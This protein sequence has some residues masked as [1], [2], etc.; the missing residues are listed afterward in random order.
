MKTRALLLVALLLMF[1][2]AAALAKTIIFVTSQTAKTESCPDLS[3]D[4][5]LYCDEIK[6]LGHTLIVKNELAVSTNTWNSDASSAD[7]IFLGNVSRQMINLTESARDF[8]NYVYYSVSGGLSARNIPVISTSINNYKN[9][10]AGILGCGASRIISTSPQGSNPVPDI[11]ACDDGS[12]SKET[13]GYLTRGY[14]GV[15]PVYTKSSSALIADTAIS[16]APASTIWLSEECVPRGRPSSSYASYPSVFSLGGTMFFGPSSPQTFTQDMWK[17]FRRSVLLMLNDYSMNFTHFTIPNYPT[18]DGK[19]LV[20]AATQP[21]TKNA[22][23]IISAGDFSSN[24]TYSNRTGFFESGEFSLGES[25]SFFISAETKDGLRIAN[26]TATVGLGKI[27][28]SQISAI[29]KDSETISVRT[30]VENPS[31]ITEAKYKIWAQNLTQLASGGL[32]FSGGVFQSEANVSEG[33]ITIEVDFSNR[34]GDVGGAYKFLAVQGKPVAGKDYLISPNEWLLSYADPKTVSQNFTISALGQNITGIR[35]SKSGNASDALAIDSS[36]ALS[37]VRKGN[38]TA[39]SAS[40]DLSKIS[41]RAYA[42]ILVYSNEFNAEIPI[43]AFV[44]KATLEGS[45]W[46][47]VNPKTWTAIIP[48]G[49]LQ[50]KNFTLTS[51]GPYHASEITFSATDSFEGL[52][53][54]EAASFL[55]AGQDS[56]ALLTLNTKSLAPGKYSGKINLRSSIGS[57]S[58]DVSIEIVKDFSS[59]ISEL[60][61][62]ITSEEILIQNLKSRGA[63]VSAAEQKLSEAKAAIELVESKWAA[64]DYDAAKSAL[65]GAKQKANSLTAEAAEIKEPLPVIPI[66]AGIILLL[67]IVLLFIFRKKIFEKFKKKKPDEEEVPETEEE[68]YTPP[69]DEGGYRTEYY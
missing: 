48:E 43:D 68:R 38:S 63:D 27:R 58:I 11:N 64:Q 17:I 52:L 40:I 8:C 36:R 56:P 51:L 24:L 23:L 1:F 20:Y 55:M 7:M 62:N 12:F 9:S 15:V 42:K 19:I 67:I 44:D 41:G 21:P 34:F 39:F 5:R 46:I 32:I 33:N 47:S 37:D 3:G 25:E 6:K 35:I 30:L 29:R 54:A 28:A 13:E 60:K 18:A 59:E 14:A 2:P 69:K 50:A 22:S 45:K 16:S 66:A 53:K 61:E 65:A 26:T 31:D 57:D 49:N 10:P 4:D